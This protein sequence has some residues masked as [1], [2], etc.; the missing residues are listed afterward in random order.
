MSFAN[1]VHTIEEMERLYYTAAGNRFLRGEDLNASMIQ[2][3]DAPALEATVGAHVVIY[4]AKAWSQL[5]HESNAFGL[6]AKR[7]WEKSGWRVITTRGAATPTGGVAEDGNI[8]ETIKPTLAL[9]STVPRTVV[10]SFNNSETLELLAT[11]GKDDTAM[12]MAFLRTHFMVEHVEHINK[13]LLTDN[14]TSASNG[15]ESIDRII[16]TAAEKTQI[17]GGA[18]TLDVYGLDRDGG[19]TW[20]DAYVN[21]PASGHAERSLTDAILRT[22][23]RNVE[24][25]GGRSSFWLTGLD[26][27]QTILGLFDSTTQYHLDVTGKNRITTSVNGIQ[28]AEGNAYGT[29]VAMLY[30][31][32]LLVSKDTPADTISRIYLLDTNTDV[33]NAVPKF[34][35]K[36]A[37]PTQYFEAGI[38][39]GTPFAQGNMLN[40]GMF[41]TMG[42]TICTVFKHQGKIRDLQ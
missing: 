22:T 5:N 21:M 40:E 1:V 7:P 39:S 6:F 8:P 25:N 12:S 3:A 4:G 26:T 34:G 14:Q 29:S 18:N 20:A 31:M 13:M 41:R 42:E 32:P 28:S 33:D 9:V 30:G 15:F 24:T 35:I 16:G 23:M 17:S 36:I 27:R 37:K 38:S 11:E 10:H 19:A 2:K